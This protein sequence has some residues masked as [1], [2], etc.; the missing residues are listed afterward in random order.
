MSKFD[1]GRDEVL[2]ALAS[3]NWGEESGNV[4]APT[5]WF[6]SVSISSDDVNGLDDVALEALQLVSTLSVAPEDLVGHFFIRENDQGFV[7]IHKF[8]SEAELSSTFQAYE[9]D[10]ANWDSQ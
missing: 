4:E 1:S 7:W 2:Y 5:G 9:K 10:Y 3:A 6:A 8:D